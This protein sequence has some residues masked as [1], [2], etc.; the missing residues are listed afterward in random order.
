MGYLGQHRDWYPGAKVVG[1]AEETTPA[2]D[3]VVLEDFI[4]NLDVLFVFESPWYQ[5]TAVFAQKHCVPI[6]C[7]PS[8]EWS[9]Y[10]LTAT[11][12]LTTSLLDYSYY[13][14]MYPD[15]RVVMLPVP[16]NSNVQWK[17]RER[18]TTFMHNGGNGSRNDRNGTVSLIEALPYIKVR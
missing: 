8:Y 5:E 3:L 2:E 6:V 10:P 13:K 9:P 4:K 12:F 17:L 14:T 15:H 7:M 18:A 11:V 16:A 1:N